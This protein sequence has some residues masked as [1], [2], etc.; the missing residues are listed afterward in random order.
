MCCLDAIYEAKRMPLQY[1]MKDFISAKT[2]R[3]QEGQELIKRGTVAEDED[4]VTEGEAIKGFS[5]LQNNSSYGKTCQSDEKF[6]LSKFV[7]NDKQFLKASLARPVRDVVQI[8]QDLIELRMINPDPTI[9]SPIY[10]GSAILAVSKMLILDFVYNCLYKYFDQSEVNICYTDT[11]SLVVRV[12]GLEGSTEEEKYSNLLRRLPDHVRERYFPRDSNDLTVG[13][14]KVEHLLQKGIFL[15][16]K[17][18]AIV[19]DGE[20]SKTICKANGTKLHQ[21][22]MLKK[23][24][25]YDAV[26]KNEVNCLMTTNHNI[27]KESRDGMFG[28]YSLAQKKIGLSAYD[29]KRVWIS[30]TESHAYGYDLDEVKLPVEERMLSNMRDR[31]NM[32]LGAEAKLTKFKFFQLL[33]CSVKH[34]MEHVGAKLTA[35]QRE[36]LCWANYGTHWQLDHI[37]P[38]SALSKFKDARLTEDELKVINCKTF[39]QLLEKI[40]HYTNIQP[41][42]NSANAK[43]KD[44]IV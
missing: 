4:M 10:L 32:Y 42:T 34:F 6:S 22:L 18:Y 23:Y 31:I 7:R 1:V 11:D 17:T 29:D 28:M 21:N 38:V 20:L 9:K 40:V 36:G 39:N 26:L 13:K 44:R 14:M 25:S 33:G 19:T 8:N 27:K 35:Q 37:I 3:R 30:D 5:K 41:L 16:P 43:K 2:K 12:D 15:K 24:E